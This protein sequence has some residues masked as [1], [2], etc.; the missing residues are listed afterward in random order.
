MKNEVYRKLTDYV[1]LMTAFHPFSY[2]IG[3]IL[4]AP[5]HLPPVFGWVVQRHLQL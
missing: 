3:R 2:K 1:Q 5:H 4:D